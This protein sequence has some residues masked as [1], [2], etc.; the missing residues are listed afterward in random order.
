MNNEDLAK[1][2]NGLSVIGR[3]GNT[4][5]VRLPKELWRSCGPCACAYC[6]GA[7]GFWD[8]LAVPIAE[9]AGERTCPVHHPESRFERSKS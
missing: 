5:F 2:L 8:T 6:K 9:K 4:I 1:E 3:H 7:E